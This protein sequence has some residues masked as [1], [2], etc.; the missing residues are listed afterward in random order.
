MYRCSHICFCIIS[1]SLY[2]NNI[3]SHSRTIVGFKPAAFC[4]HASSTEPVSQYCTISASDL[5][6]RVNNL[7]IKFPP[8]YPKDCKWD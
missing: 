5:I 6:R 1:I 3:Y 2:T 8:V 7:K 4:I